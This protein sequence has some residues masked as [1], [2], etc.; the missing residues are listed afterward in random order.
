MRLAG[1]A[2]YAPSRLAVPELV[3]GR[4]C[5]HG[6]VTA[7]NGRLPGRRWP[8]WGV[9]TVMIAALL[10]ALTGYA[11]LDSGL[12]AYATVEAHISVHAVALA[13]TVNTAVIVRAADRCCG[14]AASSRR[15]D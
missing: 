1:S 14:A 5:G 12:Q 10:L 8:R 6:T 2:G 15:S 7:K 3:P 13:V 11:A 9:R 4:V